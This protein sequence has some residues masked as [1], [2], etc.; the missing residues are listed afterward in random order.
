M[1]S[2][3]KLLPHLDAQIE[4]LLP[5]Q[6]TGETHPDRGGFV[7]ASDGMPGG[8][9]FGCVQALGFGWLCEG[10][11]YYGDPDIHRRLLLAAAFARHIR[12]PSGRFDLI[13]TNWDCGPYTAFGVQAVSPMVSAAR[14]SPLPGSEEINQQWGEIIQTTVPG[15]V[16]GGFHT[17]NH[18]WVLVSALAQALSLFPDLDALPTIEAYLAE[19]IDINPDGEYTERSTAVYNAICNRSLRLAAECLDR[20]E[21]L[22]PVRQNLDASYHLLHEDGSVVTSLSNRQ[23]RGKTV[24]PVGMIDTYYAL[25][26]ID[27]N[28]FYASVADWLSTFARAAVPWSLEPFVTHPEWRHDDLSRSPLPES[29]ERVMPASGVWRV[30]RHS[31]SATAAIG[32]TTPFSVRHGDIDVGVKICAAYFGIAQFRADRIAKTEDNIRLEFDGKGRR[33]DGPTYAHPVGRAVSMEDYR[34]VMTEREFTVMEPLQMA[35]E[36]A[37]V[38]DGFDLRLVTTEPFDNIPLEILF[39]FSPG[40]TLHADSLIAEG[41]TGHTAFLRSGYAIYHKGSDAISV[42][43]GASDHRMRDMRNSEPEPTAFRLLTTFVTPVDHTIQIR[44][45][46][47]SEATESILLSTENATSGETAI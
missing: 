30:R 47:W 21:L 15:M 7:N 4:S 8:S 44:T 3:P 26:R 46:A 43:P 35:L 16:S 6:I 29:Y 9:H 10:S 32:I 36:I 34:D 19:T 12:R 14:R 24:V 41:A 38:D 45:G 31:R 33:H 5:N 17:P 1:L 42:G 23:D 18:R 13:T 20:P 22:D 2:Y 27:G 11:R 37:E 39:A 25:A 40:G 28:E